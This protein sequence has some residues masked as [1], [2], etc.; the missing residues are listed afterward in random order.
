MKYDYDRQIRKNE[1]RRA[2]IILQKGKKRVQN[3]V[4]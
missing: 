2:Y 4:V 1:N 3:S